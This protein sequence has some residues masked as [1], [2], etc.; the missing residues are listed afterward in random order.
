MKKS[1]I[2]QFVIII[3]LAVILGILVRFTVDAMN[4]N[5]LPQMGAQGMRQPM[6]I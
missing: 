1:T 6:E 5:N 3:L 4:E 2:I